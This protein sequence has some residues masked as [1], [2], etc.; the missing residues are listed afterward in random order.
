LDEGSVTTHIKE[1]AKKEKIKPLDPGVLSSIY[2]STNGDLRQAINLFQAASASGELSLEK[3]KA[4]TGATVK[5]RVGDIVRL[6]LDGEFE[7]AR[8]KMVELTRV[9]GIP[10]RD[11]LKFA[12]E[13]LNNH[14]GD[15]LG[16]AINIH[17]WNVCCNGT[18]AQQ[19]HT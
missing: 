16:D 14:K 15:E 12:N 17:T 11:F 1:I 3:V 7:N 5:G 4:V 8:L 19:V 9:Y 13:E 6:A 10:E 2:E 18:I